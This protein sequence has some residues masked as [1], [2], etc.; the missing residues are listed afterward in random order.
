MS[1]NLSRAIELAR[2]SA[3]AE[4]TAQPRLKDL[5]EKNMLQAMQEARQEIRNE[6]VKM[7]PFLVFCFLAQDV[8]EVLIKPVRL[9]LNALV[10][11]VQQDVQ[12]YVKDDFV[13]VGPGAAG[14]AGDQ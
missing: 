12:Q 9:A 5:Y 8:E 3:H 7:K 4:L 10:K 2:K 1:K 13:L 6:R 14:Q 11:G